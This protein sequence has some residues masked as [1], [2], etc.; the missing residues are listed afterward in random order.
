MTKGK[1]VLL[2]EDDAW[3]AE[4][5]ERQLRR[6]GYRTVV[7]S[8]AQ[9]AIHCV[10]VLRP[11]VIV[12]DFMLPGTNGIGFLHELR[13]Y[14]DTAQIPVIVCSSI[15]TNLSHEQLSVYGVVAVIDKTTIQSDELAVAIRGALS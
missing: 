2:V 3:Q 6:G 9:E 1:N 13:S 11:D 4:H 7:A 10:D 14:A 15:A 12:L 8:S 5:F